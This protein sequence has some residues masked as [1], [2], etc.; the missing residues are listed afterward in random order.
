MKTNKAP[1]IEVLRWNAWHTFYSEAFNSGEGY[2][3]A[4]EFAEKSVKE[5]FGE[6]K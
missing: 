4:R 2:L 5:M 6:E 1:S 3:E